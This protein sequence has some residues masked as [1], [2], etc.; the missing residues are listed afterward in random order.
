MRSY[1]VAMTKGRSD[2][3]S[4]VCVDDGDRDSAAECA[5]FRRRYSSREI[6]RVDFDEMRR[7]MSAE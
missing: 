2:R 1:L 3:A 6:K 4:A 5:M 7:L